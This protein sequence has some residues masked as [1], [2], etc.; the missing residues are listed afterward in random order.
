MKKFMAQDIQGKVI[1]ITGASSGI[2]ECIARYLA[3]R[4][5]I[6][7]LGA[8]RLEKL[9]TIV[10]EICNHG[11]SAYCMQTNVENGAEV[12]RLVDYALECCG[13]LDVMVSNAGV[14][15]VAPMDALKTEEWFRMISTNIN[16]LLNGISASLPIFQKQGYGHFVNM[17]SV[18]GLKVASPGSTVY[19][20]TKF[21]VR[22]ISDGLRHEVG[23]R[24]RVTVISP[25]AFE[26]EL[27]FGSSH[28]VGR[29]KIMNFYS[30]V[31]VDP[32]PIAKAVEFAI[33]MPSNID[34]NE[35]VIRPTAQEF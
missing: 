16:G 4:G 8:R 14:M 15:Y 21:A 20:A 35:I 30:K 32:T 2:G 31:A 25:G 9:E 6:V 27:K 17:A 34:L 3:S 13:K 1:A 22:A 10:S 28:P 19:S 7:V 18:A 24:I 26:S 12:E 29:E 11:G 5:A 23:E 33:T